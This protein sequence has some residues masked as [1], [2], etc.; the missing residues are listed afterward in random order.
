MKD[1]CGSPDLAKYCALQSEKD[2]KNAISPYDT[3]IIVAALGGYTGSGASPEVARMFK[4]L[5]K[6]NSVISII[7]L[8]FKVE[9]D[10]RRDY[11][12]EGFENLKK[13]SDLVLILPYQRIYMLIPRLPSYHPFDP[14]DI[15][16]MISTKALFDIRNNPKFNNLLEE[17]KS[18][19][20]CGITMMGFGD[21]D[22][23]NLDEVLEMALKNP[24][25]T[26]DIKKAGE[27][28]SILYYKNSLSEGDM[29][30][31]IAKLRIRINPEANI[32]FESI[33]DENLDASLLFVLLPVF[34]FNDDL[35]DIKRLL[36]EFNEEVNFG[37]DRF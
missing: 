1:A 14:L 7:S 37:L 22:D 2:I 11:A 33:K 35:F 5:N 28:I 25:N 34:R 21:S 3:I 26:I 13:Y 12:L 24:M 32:I 31:F 4:E 16:F 17:I 29:N 9:G 27:V 18:T 6:I 30:D 19:S 36:M 20:N 8:P 23:F 15:I 10:Y